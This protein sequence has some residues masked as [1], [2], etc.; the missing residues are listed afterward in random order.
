MLS[1]KPKMDGDVTGMTIF[2]TRTARSYQPTMH[3]IHRAQERQIAWETVLA[4]LTQP[5]AV[6]YGEQTGHVTTRRI[7]GTNGL[8]VVVS[9]THDVL[10]MY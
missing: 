4:A 3:A 5:R 8:T 10:T 2:S 6:Y 9:P 7:V 1:I